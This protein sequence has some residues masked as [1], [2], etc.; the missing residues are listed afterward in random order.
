M[1]KRF[2]TLSLA[3][4]LVVAFAGYAT[5]ASSN[6]TGTHE[7][8]V[9]YIDHI[10][11]NVGATLSSNEA[12]Q[13]DPRFAKDQPS[14]STPELGCQ[15]MLNA[16][17]T[18]AWLWSLPGTANNREGIGQ[19]FVPDPGA[20]AT[21]CTVK[22]VEVWIYDWVDTGLAAQVDL[23]VDVCADDGAGLPGAV[24]ATVTIPAATVD[25]DIVGGLNTVADFSSF[26]VVIPAGEAY[27]AVFSC[28]TAVHGTSGVLLVGDD[29]TDDPVGCPEG[30]ANVLGSVW[31]SDVGYWEDLD[32]H[33]GGWTFGWYVWSEACCEAVPPECFTQ[34]N[35]CATPAWLWSLPGTANSREGIGQGFTLDPT[36][37][38]ECTLK[39]VEVWVYDWIDTGAAAKVDMEVSICA[40]DGAG[41]PGA[42][43]ATVTIPAATIDADIIGGLNTVAD[44]SAYNLTAPP[45]GNLHAIF[46]C[47]TAVHGVSGV[48]FVGD[49]GTD[50]PVGCP[51]GAANVLG[52]VWY[53]GVGYWEDLDTHFGGWTFGW[54]IWGNICCPPLLFALCTPT[55][56]T[57]YLTE[58]VDFGRTN[59]SNAAFTDPCAL[60]YLW[61]T[62]MGAGQNITAQSAVVAGDYVLIS[63]FNKLRCYDKATGAMNW[64]FGGF[65]F[66]GDDLRCTP[67][68][69]LASGRVYFGGGAFKSFSCV[70]LAGDGTA[71]LDT[72]WSRN[73]GGAPY[74]PLHAAPGLTRFA[75]SVIIGGVVYTVDEAG[76]VYALDA[77]TG[78]DVVA[79]ITLPDAPNA[80]PWN[81]MTSNGVDKLW[82]GTG[83]SVFVDGYIHQIDA[84]TLGVDWS[85]FEPSF[86]FTGDVAFDFEGFPGTLAYEDGILYYFSQIRNTDLNVNFPKSGSVGA[87]DVTGA[88]TVLW[89]YLGD[90]AAPT[91]TGPLFSAPSLSPGIVYAHARGYFSSDLDGIHAFDKNLGT[92][93]W[94]SG[95]YSIGTNLAGEAQPD[96]R[97]TSPVTVICGAD[98][99]PYLFSGDFSGKWKFW[100]GNLGLPLWERNF[101]GIVVTTAVTDDYAVVVTRSGAPGGGGSVTAFSLGAPQP[102]LHIDSE[103]VLRVVTPGDGAT[104]D[105][106]TDPIRNTGCVDLNVTGLLATD[107]APVRVS[108]IN[109]VI[110]SMAAKLTDNLGGY[111]ML[112][113]SLSDKEV[114]ILSRAIDRSDVDNQ[115]RSFANSTNAASAAAFLTI[116]TAT[117]LVLSPGASANINVTYDESG[118]NNNT[119][120]TNYI[121]I[122]SDDPDYYPQDPSGASMGLPYI[123]FSMF[124]GC[125]DASGTM[126]MGWG[127]DW[128]TNFGGVADQGNGPGFD[129]NGHAWMYDGGMVCAA[130]D[131]D[132]WALEGVSVGGPPRRAQEWGPT[133]PCGVN[134]GTASY[135]NP[136]GG[137]DDVDTVSYN[138]ID[139]ASANGYFTVSERQVYGILLNIQQ[140]TSH[141]TEF[142]EF[143]LTKITLTNEADGQGPLNDFYLGEAIDWDIAAGTDNHTYFYPDGYAVA[144]QGPSGKSAADYACGHF[145]LDGPIV[146]T[147]SLGSGGAPT[148]M[149]GDCFGDQDG[150]YHCYDMMS[151]PY[152]YASITYPGA[153]VQN[154]DVGVYVS[155]FTTTGLAEGASETFYYMTYQLDNGVMG[156]PWATDAEFDAALA[157]VKCRAKAFAGFGKGDVNCD[158]AVDL[159]DVVLLGNILD[160]LWTPTGGGIYTADTDGDG[161]YAQAD[162]DLLYDV[163]AGIQPASNMANAWRF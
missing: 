121:E 120:Y 138:Q 27:H 55:S 144:N 36:G 128:V 58:G 116:N 152:N 72:V 2:I 20:Q 103:Y 118:L 29:G 39:S 115:V 79:P 19:G 4:F 139:L 61:S 68:V 140:V 46:S 135:S 98:Q 141:S 92:E 76:H 91:L 74:T 146:G 44:F 111:D 130:V 85:L 97:S 84:A 112:I 28:P 106:I 69:D 158:G 131:N 52:S 24:L 93:L 54:Y 18:P 67:T 147:A 149:M 134:I 113:N 160:G 60:N 142:G 32:T 143:A 105:D 136:L 95:Y 159:A 13:L 70:S 53:A 153:P 133:L 37:T 49:D 110:N 154:T 82:V 62:D 150:V 132:H 41:L 48:L 7:D 63:T 86:T 66:I 73:S 163:V 78:A 57:D 89:V 83:N 119:L 90:M 156:L 148:F 99:V 8:A 21:P 34:L 17:A 122:E 3:V 129:I 125:P 47:P 12:T 64:E 162:Y 11:T 81:S 45:G 108:T 124:I 109:P 102:K 104:T 51:E 87:I 96:V 107:P 161:S 151:D 100:N 80:V 25:A 145:R 155:L 6:P 56:A 77:A 14:I 50:D 35:A 23:Q 10:R 22:T 26:N 38:R 157:D 88:P 30:A 42:V 31:Y 5:A 9:N 40:D 137:T 101:S 71:P 127:E 1:S 75:P 94:Y 123:E 16:C 117:P 65:P 43:L 59:Y 15:T 126:V 33:F 114:S